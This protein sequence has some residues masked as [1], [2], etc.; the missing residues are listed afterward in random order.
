MYWRNLKSILTGHLHT[1]LAILI[2][3]PST[4]Y[5]NTESREVI[6]LASTAK[7]KTYELTYALSS[8][9]ETIGSS[10]LQI[11]HYA[12][13]TY[14]LREYTH[15][16]TQGWWGELD[17]LSASVEQH[18]ADGRLVS[19]DNKAYDGDHVVWTQANTKRNE[20]W[21]SKAEVE[22][23]DQREEQAL[24]DIALIVLGHIAPEAGEALAVSQSLLADP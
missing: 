11:S 2:A 7:P 18:A 9:G 10:R 22:H 19:A 17:I 13:G 14:Q 5:A 8:N 3:L 15:I 23:L 20:V 1:T 16:H 12:D 21:L 24:A 4:S 6:A